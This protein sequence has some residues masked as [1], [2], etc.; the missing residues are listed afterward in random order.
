MH[1]SSAWSSDCK[2]SCRRHSCSRHVAANELPNTLT[3]V[4]DRRLLVS[5]LLRGGPPASQTAMPGGDAA[6]EAAAQTGRLLTALRPSCF[7]L[8]RLCTR[9]VL[10]WQVRCLVP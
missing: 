7:G 1:G 2:D 10:D 3:Y 5:L 6:S 8:I 9:L 4:S